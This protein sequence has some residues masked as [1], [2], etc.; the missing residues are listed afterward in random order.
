MQQGMYTYLLRKAKDYTVEFQETERT[1]AILKKNNVYDKL[2]EILPDSLAK[3][4]G[5]DAVIKCSYA[6]EK[7]VVKPGQLQKHYYLA[8]LAQKLLQGH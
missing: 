3:I 8:V 5:V 4:L 7:Q 1:N 6:Y 2:D